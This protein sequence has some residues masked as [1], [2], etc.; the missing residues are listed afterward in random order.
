MFRTYRHAEIPV[1]TRLEPGLQLWRYVEQVLHLPWFYV[2]LARRQDDVTVRDMLMIA[3]VSTLE[4]LN[5]DRA[6]DKTLETILLV[7]PAYM[8]GGDSWLMEPLLEITFVE[9]I[10]DCLS[11]YRYKVAGDKTYTNDCDPGLGAEL[12]GVDRLVLS[13]ND[14]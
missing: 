9:A 5:L 6:L 10:G 4:S 12:G 1:A 8:N 2:T 14:S 3:D 7:S 13:L 11:H